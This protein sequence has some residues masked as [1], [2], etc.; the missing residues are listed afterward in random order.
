M[1]WD[2]VAGFFDG[3]GSMVLTTDTSGAKKSINVQ[4]QMSQTDKNVLTVILD[5]LTS[6]GICGG[7]YKREKANPFSTKPIYVL[8]V[9]NR[10]NVMLMLK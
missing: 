10:R 8:I 3:E 7:I 5:F 9:A 4:V 2:Y 6:Q 1:N